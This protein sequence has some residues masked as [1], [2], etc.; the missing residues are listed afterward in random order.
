MKNKL[1]AKKKMNA[2]C[3]GS[4]MVGMALLMQTCSGDQPQRRRQLPC[5]HDYLQNGTMA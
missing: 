5:L 2:N 1:P 3:T 4:F